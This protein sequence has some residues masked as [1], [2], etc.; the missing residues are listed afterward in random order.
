MTHSLEHIQDLSFLTQSLPNA[1]E[2]GMDTMDPDFRTIRDLAHTGDFAGASRLIAPRLADEIY[3]IRLLSIYF[4]ARFADEGLRMLGPIFT[5]IGA[6]VGP[7]RDAFGPQRKRDKH[8][9]TRLEWTFAT[10]LD[11]GQYHALKKTSTW[12]RWTEN[13]DENDIDAILERG[14]AVS[15][16]LSQETETGAGQRLGALMTWLEEIAGTFQST[17]EL[18]NSSPP[19]ISSSEPS[20]VHSSLSADIDVVELDRGAGVV[21][22]AVSHTFMDLARKLRAFERLIERGRYD[23]AALVAD[24]VDRELNGFDPRVYFPRFFANYSQLVHR[25][26]AQLAPHWADDDENPHRRALKQLYRVDLEGFVEQ[27]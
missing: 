13:I 16:L 15:Q 5:G 4:V 25:H 3:D 10:I 8:L 2:P 20:P 27:D 24:D 26:I 12:A 17:G 23:R 11:Q 9:D 22:M 1:E 18:P 21:Q 19:E 14:R 7:N 6:M